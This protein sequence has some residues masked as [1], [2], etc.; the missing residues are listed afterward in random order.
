MTFDR[1]RRYNTRAKD[2]EH[3]VDILPIIATCQLVNGW[4]ILEVDMD[5]EPQQ[6]HVQANM[7]NVQS[8]KACPLQ[9]HCILRKLM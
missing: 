5:N 2:Q 9:L 8:I 7:T 3:I 6:R 1:D 4:N